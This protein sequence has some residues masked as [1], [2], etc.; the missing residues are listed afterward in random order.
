MAHSEDKIFERAK[1]TEPLGYIVKPFNKE[2]LQRTIEIGLY[3]H[4]AEEIRRVLV[5]ELRKEIAERK[6]MGEALLQ[7]EKL[8]SLGTITAGVAHEFNNILAVIM[9][10]AELLKKSF[11]DD[12]EYKEKLARI[13]MASKDGADITRR[14][15]R[16]TEVEVR[17]S[18]Y[19]LA[20]I[21]QMINEAIELTAPAVS[22]EIFLKIR[23]MMFFCHVPERMHWQRLEI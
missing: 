23:D 4:R 15:L 13:I 1:I 21:Q 19:V 16:I 17:D 6:R 3:K 20:D 12:R 18:G 5:R 9:G 11:S 10:Y 8:K 7:S 2:E 14:M 22:S